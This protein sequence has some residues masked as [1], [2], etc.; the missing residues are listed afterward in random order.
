ML[1]NKNFEI[2]MLE[3]RNLK[4]SS[5]RGVWERIDRAL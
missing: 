5:G 2:K 1:K 4:Q 3:N